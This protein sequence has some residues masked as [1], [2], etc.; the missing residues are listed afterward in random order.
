MKPAA[1]SWSYRHADENRKKMRVIA[2]GQR[3]A[4]GRKRQRE[5]PGNQV[6]KTV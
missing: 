1:D 3:T 4:Q 5:N 6:R 2:D